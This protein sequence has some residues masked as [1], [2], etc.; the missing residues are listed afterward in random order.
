MPGKQG[1]KAAK[2]QTWR[3][4]S[5]GPSHKFSWEFVSK[6]ASSELQ[7]VHSWRVQKAEERV[8]LFT[9]NGLGQAGG[10][11]RQMDATGSV[12]SNPS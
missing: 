8:R 10:S 2:G 3:G 4:A 9:K 11:R 7:P 1:D 12:F 6:V 5:L